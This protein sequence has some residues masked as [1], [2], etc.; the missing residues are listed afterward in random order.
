MSPLNLQILIATCFLVSMM[1]AVPLNILGA[2][3]GKADVTA[4]VRSAVKSDFLII[5]ASNQA[6]GDS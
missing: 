2:A 3:F 6:F 1:S 5:T 4:Q